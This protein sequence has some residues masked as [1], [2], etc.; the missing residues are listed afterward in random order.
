V[1]ADSLERSYPWT[2][3][4]FFGNIELGLELREV[5]SGISGFGD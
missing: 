3:G 5:I 4:F 1:V 2:I